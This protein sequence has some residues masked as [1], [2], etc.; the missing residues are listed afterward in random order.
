M[1]TRWPGLLRALAAGRF[2]DGVHDGLNDVTAADEPVVTRV[3]SSR[4]RL[5]TSVSHKFPSVSHS[6]TSY[7]EFDRQPRLCAVEFNLSAKAL[8]ALEDC[9]LVVRRR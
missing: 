9:C 8:V 6:V 4:M 2:P 1:R 3:C 7:V 5:K